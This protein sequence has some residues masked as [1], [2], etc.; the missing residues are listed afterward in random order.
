MK[1]TKT[2]LPL[3]PVCKKGVV[4]EYEVKSFLGL[5]GA[6]ERIQCDN[7]KCG[8]TFERKSED[9][10][11]L[12]PSARFVNKYE[13][14]TL[15]IEEWN[16]I[17]KGGLSDRELYL[18][19][20]EEGELPVASDEEVRNLGIVLKKGELVHAYG[21][22]EYWE[23][24]LVSRHHGIYG[25]PSIRV[26]R[27]VYIRTGTYSGVGRSYPELRHIDTGTLI[28]TNKRVLFT[29]N[30]RSFTIP[31][32]K[33]TALKVRNKMDLIISTEGREKAYHIMCNAPFTKILISGAIKN[34]ES[35]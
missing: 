22:V 27:G 32:R 4:R 9:A 10:L 26:A 14:E 25:G 23:E 35:D 21:Q 12:I 33:I 7:K 28:I 29:G 6:R 16:R 34:L 1:E 3:C 2:I 24:R 13:G 19:K 20:I 15:R 8:A 5:L 30:F 11:R 18:K 31:L 17:A